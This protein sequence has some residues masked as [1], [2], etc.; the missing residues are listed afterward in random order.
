MTD[1]ERFVLDKVR[2]GRRRKSL[3]PDEDLLAAG[4]LDSLS[5]M[6]L[7]AFIEERYGIEVSDEDL[8]MENFR[9]LRSIQELVEVK[10]GASI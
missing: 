6:E 10:R 4:T 1:L 9:T 2:A 8:V 7:V 5:L 3:D